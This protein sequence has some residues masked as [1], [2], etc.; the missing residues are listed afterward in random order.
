MQRCGP[1][2]RRA[3]LQACIVNGNQYNTRCRE[4]GA[5]RPDLLAECEV[6][7]NSKNEPLLSGGGAGGGEAKSVLKPDAAGHFPIRCA[8]RPSTPGHTLLLSCAS[9]AGGG[10]DGAV[11]GSATKMFRLDVARPFT[12][13]RA[14][15]AAEASR[16]YPWLQG[17]CRE[18]APSAETAPLL[19]SKSGPPDGH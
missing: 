12:M 19:S 6:L 3:W 1:T 4:D 5:Q 17:S 13:R 16:C 11:P 7:W 2:D 18:A 8:A 15:C 9:A 14:A 10:E